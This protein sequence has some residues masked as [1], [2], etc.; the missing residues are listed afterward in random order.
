MLLPPDITRRQCQDPSL[1]C[2]AAAGSTACNHAP[3]AVLL[4]GGMHALSF[5]TGDSNVVPS[6]ACS[7]LLADRDYNILPNRNYIGVSSRAHF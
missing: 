6:W 5:I 7:G 2:R 3:E 4:A 1:H